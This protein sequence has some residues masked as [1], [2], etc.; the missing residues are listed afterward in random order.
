M[1]AAS[2]RSGAAALGATRARTVTSCWRVVALAMSRLATLTQ[3][4]TRSS[5]TAA[6]RIQMVR[7]TGGPTIDSASVMTRIPQMRFESGKRSPRRRASACRSS[8][9]WASVTPSRRRAIGVNQ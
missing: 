1:T 4:I 9:A 6:H 7:A 8:R 5:M 2:P 3:A